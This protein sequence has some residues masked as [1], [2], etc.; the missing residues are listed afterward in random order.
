MHDHQHDLEPEGRAAA[1]PR[2]RDTGGP[3]APAPAAEHV[4]ALQ[5]SAGNRT[6]ARMLDDDE[7]SPVHAVLGS[8][9]GRPLDAGVR[10]DMEA[11]LGGDFGDVRVHTDAGAAAS[12]EAVNAHAY[13]SGSDIVFQRDAYDPG[14]D[15]GR[16]TLAHE[17]VHVMQQRSGPVDGTPAAGGISLSHPDD[18]FEREAEATASAAVQRQALPEE[19]EDELP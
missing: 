17:L 9:G 11:R 12:A 8:G 7:P 14:S 1:R 18:R 15:H 5:R 4:L 3:A 19:E 10:Q 16:Q 13:T 6:V 2:A